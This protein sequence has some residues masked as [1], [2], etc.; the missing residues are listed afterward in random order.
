MLF[1][2]SFAENIQTVGKAIGRF[3]EKGLK[4]LSNVR[5][6]RRKEGWD[7]EAYGNR[8][9]RLGDSFFVGR[10]EEMGL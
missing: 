5:P 7:E 8:T 10:M 3:Q 6:I 9:V 1:N 4:S 2:M